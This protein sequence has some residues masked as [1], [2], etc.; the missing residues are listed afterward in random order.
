MPRPGTGPADSG[1]MKSVARTEELP[2]D[3]PTSKLLRVVAAVPAPALADSDSGS[4][5]NSGD[6]RNSSVDV[7]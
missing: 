1:T 2:A 6:H 4:A 7:A 5:D 3:S